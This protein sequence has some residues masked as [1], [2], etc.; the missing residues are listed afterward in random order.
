MNGTPEITQDAPVPAAD[1]MALIVEHDTQY[2]YSTQVAFAQHLAHLTPLS[3]P[4]QSLQ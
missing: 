1:G 4:G 2:T 3:A